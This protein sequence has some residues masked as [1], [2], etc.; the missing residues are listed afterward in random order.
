MQG[1]PTTPLL[2]TLRVTT[3]L[4]T[5]LLQISDIRHFSL[6]LHVLALVIVLAQAT[7]IPGSAEPEVHLM[8]VDNSSHC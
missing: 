1:E 7:A 8:G 2:T 5:Q 4:S 6:R 3:G